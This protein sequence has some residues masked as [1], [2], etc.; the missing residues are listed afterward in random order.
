[1]RQLP[2]SLL[3]ESKAHAIEEFVMELRQSSPDSWFTALLRRVRT[4]IQST[5]NS[6]VPSVWPEI[7]DRARYA[8]DRPCDGPELATVFDVAPRE[9]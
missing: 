7:D 3:Y 5:T 1:L 2:P 8:G 6:V 4:A 9:R